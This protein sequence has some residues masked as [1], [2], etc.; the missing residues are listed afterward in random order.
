MRVPSS[1]TTKATSNWPTPTMSHSQ[2]DA[3]PQLSIPTP[4]FRKIPVV[5]EMTEKDTPK[6]AKNRSVLRRSWRYPNASTASCSRLLTSV[7]RPAAGR[8]DSLSVAMFTSPFAVR[9]C[10]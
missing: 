8:V 4:K 6:S 10:D 2:I 5:I 3:G 9:P 1:A 7:E